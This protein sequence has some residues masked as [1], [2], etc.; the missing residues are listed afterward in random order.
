[1][2]FNQRSAVHTLL[3]SST[4]LIPAYIGLFL[5]GIPTILCPLPALTTI[6]A[7]ILSRWHVQY[8][9]LFLPTLLFLLWNPQL[10]R[11]EG[12]IP[13]RS[14]ALFVLAAAL[15]L[16]VFAMRWKWGLQYQGLHYTV[17]IVSI[18]VMWTGFLTF[19]FRRSVTTIASFRRSLFVHWM[20]FA[21]LC[22][23]AFPWLGELI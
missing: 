3:A 22:W 21:W 15:N 19:V 9:A 18:N 5:S 10:F 16:V 2:E 14:F 11:A 13:K 8:A 20:L 4:L 6:P 7:L 12:K 17:V 1:V 23:Y